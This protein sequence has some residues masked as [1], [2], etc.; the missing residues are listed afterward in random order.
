MVQGEENNEFS[1]TLGESVIVEVC[2]SCEET[3][4]L[5]NKVMGNDFEA[6]QVLA[7]EV[8][9]DITSDLPVSLNI[10]TD[11]S[12]PI[13]DVGIWIDPIGKK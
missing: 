13:E 1:N 3:T 10:P 6:S 11:L 4:Q 12:I 7:N 8:H 2:N 9:K 5:L